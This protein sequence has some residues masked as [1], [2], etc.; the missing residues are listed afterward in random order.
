[1]KNVIDYDGQ[2]K[3]LPDVP[4]R[5]ISDCVEEMIGIL[6]QRNQ[7]GK[8]TITVD[9]SGY[10]RVFLAWEGIVWERKSANEFYQTEIKNEK[11]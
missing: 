9:Q 11:F 6:K 1:M 3:D 4:G 7:K 2:Y 10:A 8:V 5:T